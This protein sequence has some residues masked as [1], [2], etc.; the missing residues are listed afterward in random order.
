MVRENPAELYVS[1]HPLMNMPVCQTLRHSKTPFVTVV[2]DMVSAHAFWFD[3]R[4]SQVIVPVEE[5]RQTGIQLGLDPQKII[6]IGQPIADRFCHPDENKAGVRQRLG[7]PQDQLVALLVGGGDGA[8][9][10]EETALAIQNAGL[11]LFLA[12]VTGRNR[13]LRNHLESVKWIIPTRT[14]GFVHEMPDFMSAADIIITKAGSQTVNEAFIAGLPIILYSRF[15][16]QE[17]GNVLYIVGEKAGVWAPKSERVVNTLQ[18][19]IEFPDKRQ[20][21][22]E[23]SKRLGRPDASRQIAHHLAAQ[24]GVK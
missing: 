24:V 23:N 13:E 10:L 6:V 21:A 15:L 17:D 11:N 18:E 5:A 22:A 1:V 4:A 2:T 19:W 16:G 8:G 7:W 3:R 12:V 9:P 14:Y 20:Q